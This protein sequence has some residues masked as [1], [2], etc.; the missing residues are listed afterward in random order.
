MNALGKDAAALALHR[1]GF[2]P[3]HDS[4]K[5]IAADPRGALL[6]DLDRPGA[7]FLAAKLP[8]SA[9]AARAVSDFRAVEQ[10]KAKL[11][12]SACE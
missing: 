2:G 10:A 3:S 8:S 12:T 7:G 4:I 5:A 1:F 6:A 9:A 11:V